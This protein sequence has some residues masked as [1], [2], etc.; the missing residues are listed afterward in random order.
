MVVFKF[1]KVFCV[2]IKLLEFKMLLIFDC[3][4][5]RVVVSIY[6]C[7]KDLDEII[8]ILFD[9]LVGIIFSILYFNIFFNDWFIYV[10]DINKM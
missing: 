7:D 3:L 6:L 8:F 5:V 4:C 2:V 10:F 9:K 1:F